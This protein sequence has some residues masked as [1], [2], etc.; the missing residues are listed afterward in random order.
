M[1][2]EEEEEKR[3]TNKFKIRNLHFLAPS[4]TKFE[5]IEKKIIFYCAE[6][7]NPP[8]IVVLLEYLQ[9]VK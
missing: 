8:F 5:H 7:K 9:K 1:N 4:E 6:K 3:K 2:K